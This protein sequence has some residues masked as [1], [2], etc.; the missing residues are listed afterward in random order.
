MVTPLIKR[1]DTNMRCTSEDFGSS[2]TRHM[3]NDFVMPSRLPEDR[4]LQIIN[5]GLFLNGF[6]LQK[7]K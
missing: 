5:K 6:I 7:L 4:Y 2:N 1:K 3:H